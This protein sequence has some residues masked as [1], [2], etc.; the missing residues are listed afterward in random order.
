M[1][2]EYTAPEAIVVSFDV[3][4]ELL[5]EPGGEPGVSTVPDD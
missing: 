5:G 4:E 2:K 1:K 3:A